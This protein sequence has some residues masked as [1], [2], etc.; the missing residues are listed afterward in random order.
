MLKYCI[1]QVGCKTRCGCH[2]DLNLE[3]HVL[4]DSPPHT[5]RHA[6]LVLFI[7]LGVILT[8]KLYYAQI[9]HVRQDVG[10]IMI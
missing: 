5:M 1:V 6:S 10:V 7:R 8:S 3:C 4:L 9:L 2:N